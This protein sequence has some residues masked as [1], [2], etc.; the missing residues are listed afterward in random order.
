[1]KKYFSG[2]QIVAFIYGLLYLLFFIYSFIPSE[3]GNPV[4][5]LV[6]Y[7]PYD[8]EQI[9]NKFLFVFFLVGLI[10]SWKNK[11]ISGIL[12]ILTYIGM[13]CVSLFI[14]APMGRDFDMGIAMGLPLLIFGILF[15]VAWFRKRNVSQTVYVT[16]R[17]LVIHGIQILRSYEGRV[18]IFKPICSL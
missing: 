17:M 1:M 4:S 3:N 10:M 12:L 16:S 6:P 2:L 14:V 5:D 13:I 15:M 9:V 8:L 18:L 11:L 7:K